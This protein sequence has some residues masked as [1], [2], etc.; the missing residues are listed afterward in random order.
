[1]G[2]TDANRIHPRSPRSRVIDTY[3]RQGLGAKHRLPN[4]SDQ[5]LAATSSA[6]AYDAAA[7][8]LHRVVPG[9]RPHGV[10]TPPRDDWILQGRRGAKPTRVAR[11]PGPFAQATRA[12]WIYIA[13]LTQP[14]SLP[15]PRHCFS[16]SAPHEWPSIGALADRRCPATISIC[17]AIRVEAARP[18]SYSGY[19]DLVASLEAWNDPDQR[20]AALLASDHPRRCPRGL[21][22]GWLCHDRGIGFRCVWF[23]SCRSFKDEEPNHRRWRNRTH[24]NSRPSRCGPVHSGKSRRR[25]IRRNDDDN[26]RNSNC[27]QSK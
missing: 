7:S 4:A 3:R 22:I 17:V 14:A 13:M 5:W 9:A 8:P 26:E 24:K 20:L 27:Q 15:A 1:M 10:G 11:R 25:P 12:A 2:E 21:C 6:I 16:P 19:L 23:G 18:G